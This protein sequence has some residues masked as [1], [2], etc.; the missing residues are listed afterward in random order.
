VPSRKE[1]QWSQ[2]RVGVLVLAAM[3]VLVA[4]IFLM[5]NTTGGLFEHRLLLRSYF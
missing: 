5:S 4:L 2:L 3:A 1:I